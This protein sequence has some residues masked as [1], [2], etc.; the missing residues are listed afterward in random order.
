MPTRVPC[1]WAFV[2]LALLVPVSYWGALGLGFSNDDYLV[3]DKV[4]RV[5][6]GSLFGWSDL[7]VGWWRPW[8]R[9]IHFAWLYRV[10]GVQAWAYH[11]ANQ[12]LWLACL[13][14]IF[15]L[16]RRLTEARVALLVCAGALAASTWGLFLVWSSCSQD[17]WMLLAGSAFLIAHEDGRRGRAALALAVALL[18][19]ETAVLFVPLAAW[20]RFA[21]GGRAGLR[22]RE[23]YLPLS[24]VL[25]WALLH[26][27]V[28][29]RWLLGSGGTVTATPRGAVGTTLAAVLAPFNLE[30]ALAPA[31]GMQAVWPDCL[32]WALVTGGVAIWALRAGGSVLVST[33]SRA[34]WMRLGIGWWAIGWSPA[35]L[36]ALQWHSYY[37]WLGIVGFWL[38]TVA[39][40]L[41]R[42][43][44]LVLLLATV[45]ALRPIVAATLTDDWSTEAYQVR[46]ARLT[47]TL[48][49]ELLATHP[50]LPPHSR[51]FLADVPGGI[52]FRTGPR[53]SAAMHVWYGDTTIVGTTF[54]DYWPRAA[55]GWSS[56][57]YF[58]MVDHDLRLLP[59]ASVPIPVP[60]SLRENELWRL[61]EEHVAGQ[62][63]R[64]GEW[65]LA[66]ENYA[67]LVDAYPDTVR[68]IQAL[69]HARVRSLDLASAAGGRVR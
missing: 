38:A 44:I 55:R 69:A 28:G 1:E 5:P 34:R 19:K 22:P 30:H 57:D 26:P 33:V 43:R 52:A 36:P 13:V 31:G 9:E 62:F 56:P 21:S 48:R 63:E 45:A 40:L 6:T 12:I 39:W 20:S 60:D 42:P 68:F 24:V 25:G 18:S 14:L 64:A 66:R 59:V 7:M 41:P 53:Y 27:A 50:V 51:V 61:A 4:M 49:R 11:A 46:A 16:L 10:F 8:S 32:L 15:V 58:Y 35:L 67:R 47:E 29:G 17:L 65:G 23:W 37:G 3:L 2:A 54:T